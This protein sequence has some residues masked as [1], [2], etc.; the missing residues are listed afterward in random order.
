MVLTE[1][2]EMTFVDGIKKEEREEQIANMLK[3]G[4]T[5]EQIVDFCDYPMKLVL[6]VQ[7]N[8]KSVQKH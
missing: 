5:P 1:F 6:E 2:D 4:K 3:K 7:S 8:L